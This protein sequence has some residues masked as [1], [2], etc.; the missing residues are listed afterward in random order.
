MSEKLKNYFAIRPFINSGDCIL[1]KGRGLISRLI[2]LW[3]EYSH[4]SLV[5]KLEEF[6]GL[7]NRRFLLEALP[8]GI[9]L[10]L[11]SERLKDYKGEAYW[12]QL[13]LTSRD[14]KRK[15]IVEWALKQVGKK[16]D[17]GS[18]LKNAISRVNADGRKYFCSEFVYMAYKYVGLVGEEKA[19]RPGDIVK[20]EE[21][22]SPVSP[23]K[24]I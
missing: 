7:K 5:L 12:M 22:F 8:S 4:A 24:L 10:R 9:E 1:W 2:R 20:W 18:L 11:L 13:D 23:F 16:Y 19:P 17:F 6:E 3:S 15:N 14:E 21:L